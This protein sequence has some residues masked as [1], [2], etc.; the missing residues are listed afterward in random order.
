MKI[1]SLIVGSF[2]LLSSLSYAAPPEN[3]DPALGPFFKSLKIPG[4]NISCCDMSDCRPVEIRINNSKIEIYTDSKTFSDGTNEW[5]G[6]PEG[7]VLSP[8]ENP[9]G[10]PIA[11]WTK[12]IGVICFLNGS[13]V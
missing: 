1:K 10:E 7:R 9:V 13:G 4:T 5:V 6:V 2:L 3:A 11:C 8:R 12:P